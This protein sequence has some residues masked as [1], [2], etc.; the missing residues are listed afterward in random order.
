LPFVA[1]YLLWHFKGLVTINA[2]SHSAYPSL[3][4][5]LLASCLAAFVAALSIYKI[6]ELSKSVT[7][8]VVGT[9]ALTLLLY[10]VVF[11]GARKRASKKAMLFAMALIFAA[12]SL[13][14]T[15]FINCNYDASSPRLFRL[16]VVNK[17]VEQ[18]KHTNYFITVTAWGHFN[19]QNDVNVSKEDFK[20]IS[21][22]DTIS[23]YL[24]KGYLN[25]PWYRVKL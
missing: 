7:Y 23:I 12:Y 21:I 17:H 14:S 19:R 10:C 15:I 25:I 16:P 20:K 18:G 13:G 5:V 22:H 1:F 11:A 24:F 6:H 4:F 2:D 9:V 3:F 8:L